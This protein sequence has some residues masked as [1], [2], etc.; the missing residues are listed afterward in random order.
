MGGRSKALVLGGTEFLGI[1]LV[2]ELIDDGWE[3]TLFN[4][5]VTNPDLFA[6][7]ARLRGDRDSDVTALAGHE[8]DVVYDL[9]A[10]HPE[11]ITRSAEHLAGHCGHYVFISTISVY[12]GFPEPGI[13]EDAPLATIEGPVPAEVDGDSYGALK[14]LCERRVAALFE[15]H[16]IVRPAIIAGPHDP[17]D[18]FTYW[19][20]RLSTPGPHLVPPVL[21]TPVQYIDARDL[22]RWLVVLGA[23]R[24]RGVFNAAAAPVRFADL[25]D[26]VAE[27]VDTPLRPVQLT[28]EQLAA[29]EVRPWFD[30]PLWLPPAEATMRGF[31]GID[32]SAAAEA[33]LRHRPI[34]ETARDTL[35]WLRG[36]N[37]EVPLLLGLSPEREAELVAEYGT[38]A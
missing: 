5:G 13:T 6:S 12:D 3:V 7:S 34:G 22:A 4:R 17:S 26:A 25:L 23:T 28:E 38:D 33:G 36:R 37:A 11:Q 16:T 27:A 24:V 1:H 31:F 8:W 35:T 19:V 10:S 21:D 20:S 18:R 32:S 30:L 2:T 15:S 29:E 14:A 9:T